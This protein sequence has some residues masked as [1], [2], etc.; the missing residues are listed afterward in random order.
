MK[1]VHRG[2]SSTPS[3]LSLSLGDR[4][5]LMRTAR[6]SAKQ[7]TKVLEGKNGKSCICHCREVSRATGA[8]KPSESQKAKAPFR[9]GTGVKSIVIQLAKK[10]SWAEHKPAWICGK[11][12]SK[13]RLRPWQKRWNAW[14]IP[15]CWLWVRSLLLP[16]RGGCNVL[17]IVFVK[18]LQL[19]WE[20]PYWKSHV[21]CNGLRLVGVSIFAKDVGKTFLGRR[22]A[23]PGPM[24][25][26]TLAHII[27]LLE[28]PGKCGTHSE[29]FFFFYQEGAQAMP[30]KPVVSA[31]ALK[32]C[33]LIG[34]HLLAAEDEA[35]SSDSQSPD[36]ADM[37]RYGCPKKPGL[38]QRRCVMDRKRRPFY[39]RFS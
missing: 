9:P 3:I 12:V 24:G 7:S 5:W 27:Q 28:C 35:G 18:I 11:N 6:L 23:L 2:P 19:M 26:G 33:A 34:L 10:I 37:W 30:L 39:V 25:P 31:E 32:A 38:G 13:S 8:T 22:L 16:V 20:G 14:Q 29:L 4:R 21:N 15:F 17:H 36:A 1:W